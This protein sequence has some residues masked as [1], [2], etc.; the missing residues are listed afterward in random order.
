[1][2]KINSN[3]THQDPHICGG[4]PFVNHFYEDSKLL[5][6][7]TKHENITSEGVTF[8]LNEEDPEITYNLDQEIIRW[9]TCINS[10]RN[11]LNKKVNGFISI[12]IEEPGV[13]AEIF[14]PESNESRTAIEKVDKFIGNLTKVLDM[15]ETNIII[16]STPGFLEVST[17][18]DKVIDLD[19][20]KNNLELTK[21]ESYLAIGATPII[22]I[23][24]KGGKKLSII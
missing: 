17:T 24:P 12:Y 13:S 3:N 7:S 8:K 20:I 10:T 19:K 14:G 5:G 9:N 15:E 1:M 18:N 16:L 6:N 2:Q 11:W 23:K 4:W 21:Q 22:S